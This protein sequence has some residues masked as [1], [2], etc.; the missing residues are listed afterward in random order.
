[1][2]DWAADTGRI[3]LNPALPG[4]GGTEIKMKMNM[5]IIATDLNIKNCDICWCRTCDKRMFCDWGCDVHC[6][7][8]SEM[9]PKGWCEY[10]QPEKTQYVVV[11]LADSDTNHYVAEVV[12]VVSASYLEIARDK[13]LLHY[14]ENYAH[15]LDSDQNYGLEEIHEIGPD[16]KGA[17]DLIQVHSRRK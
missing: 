8:R 14:Q 2:S 10:Y 9:P 11:V 5:E 4:R 16:Y 3:C 7:G 15:L 6:G 12:Y 1:M 17:P 13:A